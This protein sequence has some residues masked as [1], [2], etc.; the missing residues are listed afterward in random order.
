MKTKMMIAAGAAFASVI[1]TGAASA[2]PLAYYVSEALDFNPEVGIVQ[3]N[4]LAILQE[5]RRAFAG[6]LPRVDVYAGVGGE[7]S[8][9]PSTRAATGKNSYVDLHREEMGI[10]ITQML[11]DG[12]FTHHEVARHDARARG[13]AYRVVD[14]A[15]DVAL[16][17]AEAYLGV[18]REDELVDFAKENLE[19]HL[20]VYD[21]ISRR[22][23]RGVGRRADL[24]QISGR[25]ALARSNLLAAEGNAR[26]ARATFFRVTGQN[27]DSLEVPLV[28]AEL[29]ADITAALNRALDNHPTLRAAE[30]DVESA[31]SQH[32]VARAND[33]PRLDLELGATN[34][35]EIDGVRGTD[36]DLIAMVRMNYNIYGGGSDLA[37]KRETAHR[38]N[39]AKEV[40]D[41]AH[42][43]VIES[44]QLSWND[45][46]TTRQRLEYLE[47]HM[48][49]SLAS[50]DAYTKQFNI[51][52]RTLLD[53]LDTE[54]EVFSAQSSYVAAK[55]RLIVAS[56]RV[57]NS[58][59]TLL[60]ALGLAP[61]QLTD[62]EVKARIRVAVEGDNDPAHY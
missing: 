52:Q 40:R 51:G 13:E 4:Q 50:R 32:E 56:F 8:N 1:A 59:G 38:I 24:D 22:S 20:R 37:R 25:L 26:D 14:A 55:Y 9:N 28:D 45:Y 49:S 44:M 21:Q 30:A 23:E 53:L 3:N 2:E 7:R 17:T 19:A 12:F 27:A 58:M 61:P 36:E 34:N 57:Y 47:G 39:V 18:L 54:N 29:P 41:R 10:S 31:Y 48:K 33:C 42:D 16:A 6:Y 11:F 5:R 60:P 43:E 62:D 35:H 15:E 46:T